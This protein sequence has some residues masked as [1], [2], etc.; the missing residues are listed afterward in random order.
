MSL[1]S[2]AMDLTE[3]LTIYANLDNT[4]YGTMLNDLITLTQYN[5]LSDLFYRAIIDEMKL[6]L[7][8]LEHNTQII[9]TKVI[10]ELEYEVLEWKGV[11]Y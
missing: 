2:E 10:R 7:I 4:K 3:K 8:N 11:D 9:K 5:F 6:C 1:H